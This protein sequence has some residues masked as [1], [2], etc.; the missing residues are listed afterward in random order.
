MH[1]TAL[2]IV[3][4][5]LALAHASAAETSFDVKSFGAVGDG[6]AKDKLRFNGRFHE[7]IIHTSLLS[8]RIAPSDWQAWQS[9]PFPATLNRPHSQYQSLSA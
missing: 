7:L 9:M 6:V 2:A 3:T 1:R 5:A 8:H 4:L